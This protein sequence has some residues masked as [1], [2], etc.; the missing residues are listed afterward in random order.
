MAFSSITLEQLT[1]VFGARNEQSVFGEILNIISEHAGADAL[2]LLELQNDVLVPRAIR[3][4]SNDTLGRRFNPANHPRLNIILQSAS[5][6]KFPSDADLADPY[7]GLIPGHGE[8]LDVHDCMGLNIRIDNRTWGLL[9]LDALNP[10]QMADL[11]NE[12]LTTLQRWLEVLLPPILL[13]Q[14]LE[15]L[16][17]RTPANS[18]Q[19]YKEKD[20]IIG[21]S[22]A[23][24]QL[25]SQVQQVA[26]SNLP[27]LITGET[28]TGKELI[29]KAVYTQSDRARHSLVYINCAAL[30]ESLVETELFGH[31]K[32][33]FSGA[34]EQRKGRFELADKG[35]LFLDEVGELPLQIQAKLLRAI[36]FGEIQRLGSDKTH[37]I[38]VRVVAA[39][40]RDL[41]TEVKEGKFRADLYHRLCVFPIHVVALRERKDDVN[42]LCGYFLEKIRAQF[43]F[44]NLR[45]SASVSQLFHQ[46]HWPGNIRELEHTLSRA[47]L[48]ARTRN[49]Q[50][51]RALTIDTEDIDLLSP[52]TQDDT[53]APKHTVVTK[54]SIE[55]SSLDLKSATE[56]FQKEYI[57]TEVERCS[58]NWSLAAK[59]LG[60]YRS[61]LHRLAK[62][63]GILT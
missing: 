18:L 13:A 15:R 21:K 26:P 50:D 25:L 7:D 24:K 59:N 4:L 62:R 14:K 17:Q 58:G 42:L 31:V 32:G 10:G 23:I 29:A 47:A 39:T 35:T 22:E 44:A 48:K 33:A 63:L 37:K 28:G 11:N 52:I 1:Q 38:D 53:D 56:D 30:P 45:L 49:P 41:A 55:Y 3:G 27:V 16:P 51:S 19:E 5:P 60:I 36:Q 34:T 9:T 2:A 54:N 61:N 20:E 12:Q 43:G 8:K 57:L 46:Y 6:I 40:N